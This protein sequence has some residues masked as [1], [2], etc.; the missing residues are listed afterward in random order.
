MAPKE[1]PKVEAPLPYCNGQIVA[2]NDHTRPP[3][4]AGQCLDE[5]VASEDELLDVHMRPKYHFWHGKTWAECIDPIKKLKLAKCRPWN[6]GKQLTAE[7]DPSYV[8][9]VKINRA[10]AQALKMLEE[11]TSEPTRSETVPNPGLVASADPVLN[12]V[13]EEVKAKMSAN[14][15]IPPP[16]PMDARNLGYHGQ[17]VINQT[18]ILTWT[19][20]RGHTNAQTP[21][22]QGVAQGKHF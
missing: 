10:R 2:R 12:F 5:D 19:S 20:K 7:L 18:E 1:Q 21:Q 3:G 14:A 8:K 13:R 17:D 15:Q 11:A 6:R 22:G 16:P 9:Q 4:L